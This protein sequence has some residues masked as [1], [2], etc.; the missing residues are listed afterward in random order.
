[1]LVQLRGTHS[2]HYGIGA[3]LRAETSAGTQVRQLIPVT[4]YLT[5]DEP[6]VHFG[7]GDETS[8]RT[9][10]IH[11]PSGHRQTLDDVPADRLYV[12]REPDS[13]APAPRHPEPSPTLFRRSTM[14]AEARHHERTF[15]DFEREPLLP[16]KLS[17]LGP[18][19]ASGDVDGDRDEDL[20][21]GGAAGQS[22]MIYLNEGSQRFTTARQAALEADAAC[23][24]MASLLFDAD[25]DGDLDLL[26]VS[27]GVECER[28]DKLLQDRLYLNDGQGHFHSAPHGTLPDDRT[29]GS[30]AAA[31]D[32]DRDGDL[33]LF[34]GGRVIPGQY[35]L[36][37]PSRLL[38]N[39]R[40]RFIDVT[41]AL[42][43]ELAQTGLVTGAV[44]SDA[45]GD[46]WLDLVVTHEWG[47]VKLFRNDRGRLVDQ[48]RAAGLDA[49]LGWWNG[50]AARD[51]NGDGAM[52]YVVTNFGLNTKYH[53]S[54]KNPALLFYGDFD[55][56]G[57][58]QLVEAEYE[59]NTLFPVRGKSCSTHAMPFL[60]GKFPTFKSFAIASLET[61]YTPECLEKAQRF[62]ATTFESGV[63]LNDGTGK[64]TFHALPHLAQ[65]SPSFGVALT[66]INGDGNADLYLVQNFFSPQ[67]ET[68]RMD[69][70]LS[71]LLAGN[72]D[73]TFRPIEP[74]QSGLVVPGDAKSLVVTDLNGDL[75]PDFVVGVNDDQAMAFEHQGQMGA[76]V[77]EVRLKGPKGN[78]TAIGARVTVYPDQGVRQTAEVHAGSG[79]LSQPTPALTF[80]LW[81]AHL[82]DR[83][84]V[85]WPDGS[86][87]THQVPP[88][89]QRVQIEY[90]ESV[91]AN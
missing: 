10:T 7:L 31:C 67:V 55:G 69:G 52:D 28:E 57:H 77:L 1:V 65:A 30:A 23:E 83:I 41:Q 90:A 25:G 33:D 88:D 35:P 34:I 63:L 38:R 6:M 68:G 79:Y 37:P 12:I 21:L 9:L 26:V 86:Q 47:P 45:D 61:I 74:A 76:R 75:W 81:S 15:D 42:A 58:M 44:W 48:T 80:G 32:F 11:W 27:G 72:G 73:G 40:G 60:G 24:D 50:I 56:S 18:G 46:G 71:L 29:S 59:G 19:L 85:R 53:A 87:S 89:Q 5:S 36:A 39:D 20:Y 54:E 13:P 84:E 66:E 2:N 14:L 64:F 82:I 49:L 4:G 8:I 62:E 70:G 16:N 91:N 22:G 3:V 17:Q 78:P 43:P 51:L